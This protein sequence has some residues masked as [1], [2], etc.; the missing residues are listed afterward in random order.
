[1]TKVVKKVDDKLLKDAEFLPKLNAIVWSH[2]LD[3]VDFESLKVP[4]IL[5]VIKMQT[6]MQMMRHAIQTLRLH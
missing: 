4:W 3:L 6:T 1:M 5:N 2:Y